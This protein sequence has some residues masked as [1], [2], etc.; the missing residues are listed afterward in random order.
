MFHCWA[1]IV[2]YFKTLEETSTEL[3]R[4]CK[5]RF[6]FVR[7]IR[8]S[9]TTHRKGA[10]DLDWPD[11]NLHRSAESPMDFNGNFIRPI[12]RLIL[13]KTWVNI[14]YVDT[15]WL[16]HGKIAQFSMKKIQKWR[17]FMQQIETIS[18]QTL[19][20]KN[21]IVEK[22]NVWWKFTTQTFDSLL[23]YSSVL[24]VSY[25]PMARN[26]FS[27]WIF[28]K[29]LFK[30]KTNCSGRWL[31]WI[32]SWR[33]MKWKRTYFSLFFYRVFSSKSIFTWITW[34]S[35]LEIAE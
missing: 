25:W 7:T 1:N 14:N 3:H 2:G 34:I 6:F 19:R 20:E 27:V 31:N 24:D 8:H 28:F 35:L 16:V 17:K 30:D 29:Y 26:I 13:R 21:E 10:S 32:W 33:K 9:R 11:K 15:I 18:V 5:Y 23:H 22:W 4:L 12:N